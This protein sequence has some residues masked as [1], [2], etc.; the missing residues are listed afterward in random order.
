MEWYSGW[1][2]LSSQLT[3]GLQG[4]PVDQCRLSLLL[5]LEALQK[6]GKHVVRVDEI[7]QQAYDANSINGTA[8]T[9][10]NNF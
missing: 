9:V 5:V 6:E 7:M 2:H 3:Q 1:T 8:N 10:H 4:A